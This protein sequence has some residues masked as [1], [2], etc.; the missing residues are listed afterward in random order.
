[1]GKGKEDTIFFL[2]SLP[3]KTLKTQGIRVLFLTDYSAFSFSAFLFF[4]QKFEKEP[5]AAWNAEQNILLI[6]WVFSRAINLWDR[7]HLIAPIKYV[8]IS[9]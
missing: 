6:S 7:I 1:M 9:V 5:K 8:Y 4:V 3:L 2:P